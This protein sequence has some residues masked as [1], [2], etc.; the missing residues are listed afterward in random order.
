MKTEEISV[1]TPLT[2]G[3]IKSALKKPI[4]RAD[5]LP[6]QGGVLDE[7]ADLELLVEKKTLGGV[8]AVQVYAF[9]DGDNRRVVFVALG[10]SGLGRAF[11]GIKNTA[12]LTKSV[13]FAQEMAATLV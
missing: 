3:Q 2:I 8:A 12:S 6:V 10:Q 9:D 7:P 1:T 11:G 4:G 5:V 13:A